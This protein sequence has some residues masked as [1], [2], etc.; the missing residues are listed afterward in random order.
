M[1]HR[2]V[3]KPSAEKQLEKIPSVYK[4]KIYS[5]LTAVVSSPFQGKK[6]RGRHKGY[7]AIR[8]WPYRVIYSVHTRESL[9][10]VVRIAHRQGSY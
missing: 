1:E 6:L 3:F 8:A 5:I 4:K 10:I 7:Y 9:V 2:L